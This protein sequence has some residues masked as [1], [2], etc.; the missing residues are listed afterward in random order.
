MQKKQT[1]VKATNNTEDFNYLEKIF[2]EATNN[3]RYRWGITK[4]EIFLKKHSVLTKKVDV[5][6]KLGLLYDHLA[7]RE[8]NKRRIHEKKAFELY[9]KVLKYKPDYYRAV[10]GIGRIWLHRGSKKSIPYA[11]KAYKLA[12]KGGIPSAMM[13]QSVGLTYEAVG[14]YKN[15]EKWFLKGIEVEP[16]NWGCYLNLVGFYRLTKQFSKSKFYAKKLEKLFRKESKEFKKTLWGQ[17]ILESIKDADK[18]LKKKK[19][20]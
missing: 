16:K 5:L 10:W 11:L 18:E 12:K 15:A 3:Y 6:Y 17:K 8:K 14:D 13:T 2:H 4:F 20:G 9:K 19:G 7:I 1:K